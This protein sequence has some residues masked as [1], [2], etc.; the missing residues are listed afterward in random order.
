MKNLRLTTWNINSVRLR[1]DL[2]TRFLEDV[3][4]DVICLQETKVPDPMFPHKAF[5][6]LGYTHHAV[7]GQKGYHGVATLS[8]IPLEN[9]TRRNWCGKEDA[10]HAHATLPGGIEVHN[11]YIPAGGDIP[12]PAENEKFAHKMQFLDEMAEWFPAERSA[13]DKMILV[14]DLNVAPSE[15]DVWSH[16][17]LLKVVSHTPIEVEKLAA[18]QNSVD[19]V[20]AVR[21]V[22]PEPEKLFSWWSYRSPNWRTNN[23]GRRL[24][25]IW[26][27]PPLQDA[28]KSIDILSDARD[29]TKPSDHAPIT[30]DLAF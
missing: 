18:V 12:D 6:K 25:H 24:D 20:D 9:P 11:F 21:H 23:R 14:G 3:Q 30:V 10:R 1:I 17:Q 16:K 13:R 27:T 19:W 5:D 7:A 26:V 15:F 28:V 22:V 8:K 29:W 2:V 4:P